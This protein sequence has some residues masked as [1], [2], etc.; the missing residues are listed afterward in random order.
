MCSVMEQFLF[1]GSIRGPE[2]SFGLCSRSWIQSFTEDTILISHMY[3]AKTLHLTRSPHWETEWIFKIYLPLFLSLKSPWS[4]LCCQP[5]W[6]WPPRSPHQHPPPP[7]L[8]FEDAHSQLLVQ[9]TIYLNVSHPQTND[10]N[11]FQWPPLLLLCRLLQTPST[12]AQ[13][14]RWVAH[15]T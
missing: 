1:S 4:P 8:S 10:Q 12:A 5:P 9:P 14:H 13:I 6:T 7:S 11:F 2:R 3:L 15:R